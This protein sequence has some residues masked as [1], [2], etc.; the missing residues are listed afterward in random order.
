LNF[1]TLKKLGVLTL[2]AFFIS[3]TFSGC[4]DKSY[5]KRIYD[6]ELYTEPINC[7]KLK[8]EPYSEDVYNGIK[9]MYSFS[10]NCTKTLHIK[11]KTN[12]G[13]NSPHSTNKQ[14]FHS[15]IELSLYHNNKRYYIIYKD[16]KD[17]D[18][19]DEIKKAFDYLKSKIRFNTKQY[20]P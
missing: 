11:Y 13:C 8:L 16:L 5:L 1:S 10:N 4:E 9:E 14:G 18:I 12:I 15:Y 17:E 7:L 3:I 20:E 2:L 19:N 6:E